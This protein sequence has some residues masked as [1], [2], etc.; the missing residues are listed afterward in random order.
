[1]LSAFVKQNLISAYLI[2]IGKLCVCVWG[3]GGGG[4]LRKK[5][6]TMYQTLS[7]QGLFLYWHFTLKCLFFSHCIKFKW[8][9][10]KR[11]VI[12]LVSPPQPLTWPLT[13][14]LWT[15]HQGFP[16]LSDLNHLATCSSKAHIGSCGARTTKQTLQ[17]QPERP[18]SSSGHLVPYPSYLLFVTF[19]FLF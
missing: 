8:F 17:P 9:L 19:F 14:D 7:S 4:R 13:P 5:S 3:G 15:L 18:F 2:L 6:N 12:Q 1:M 10:E 16:L 11:D